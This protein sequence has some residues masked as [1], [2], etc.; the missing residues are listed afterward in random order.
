MRGV[1]WQRCTRRRIPSA[2][3]RSYCSTLRLYG[4][5]VEGKT[6]LEDRGELRERW[7]TQ[8]FSD[9]ILREGC[10]TLYASA[11]ERRWFANGLRIGASPAVAYE[12]HRAMDETDLREVL[13]AVR[14][15]TLIATE[16]RSERPRPRYLP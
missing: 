13:P 7:G 14:V 2:P 11:D 12:L 9:E 8:E 1:A 3:R 5:A 10:P 4:D 15:P 16:P 6:G